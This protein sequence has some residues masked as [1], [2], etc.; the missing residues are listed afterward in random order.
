[1]ETRASHN[2]VNP[3]PRALCGEIIVASFYFIK[4]F[5]RISD[6]YPP[7]THWVSQ[8]KQQ[9]ALQARQGFMLFIKPTTLL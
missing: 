3:L 6:G 8:K 2:P 1:V 9:W 4:N 7:D 5:P